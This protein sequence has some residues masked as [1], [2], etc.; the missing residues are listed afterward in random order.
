MSSSLELEELL[1]SSLFLRRLSFSRFAR[2]NVNL[3]LE[4][5]LSEFGLDLDEASIFLYI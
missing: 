1:C 5:F 3:Q 2:L 4:A